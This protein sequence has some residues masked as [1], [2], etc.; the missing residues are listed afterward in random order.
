MVMKL[1]PIAILLVA[2]F[3]GGCAQWKPEAEDG[4]LALP[5]Q[6]MSTDTV[7]LE[8]ISIEVPADSVALHDALWNQLDE[9]SIPLDL[10]QRMKANGLRCG[11]AST[12]LPRQVEELLARQ[13]IL[14]EV[15]AESGGEIYTTVDLGERWQA[16][17]GH[18][19]RFAIT[20]RMP[21]ATWI[22]DEG[23]NYLRGRSLKDAQCQAEIISFPKPD[24]KVRIELLPVIEHGQPKPRFA[25]SQQAMVYKVEPDREE[26]ESLRIRA[27][28]T[29][30]QTLILSQ[31]A[32]NAG[33]GNL[34]FGSDE[35]NAG[36][37][38]ILLVR[39]AQTQ[40]DELFSREQI[41]APIE[42]PT[43]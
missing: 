29:A 9:T 37:K 25:A 13:T 35:Q 5:A 20:E 6:R 36:G 24:G 27:E 43:E 38:K 22:L 31:T 2:S 19:K 18:P 3:V 14:N 30:G 16:R 12:R 33:L 40:L 28:M 10:R 17:M 34:F 21:N 8:V 7:V 39:I 26:F 23:D 42:T 11:I 32:D 41:F 15:R 1:L 4:P